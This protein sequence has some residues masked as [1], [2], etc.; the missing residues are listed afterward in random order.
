MCGEQAKGPIAVCRASIALRLCVQVYV[1]IQTV[2]PEKKLNAEKYCVARVDVEIAATRHRRCCLVSHYCYG[3][4]NRKSCVHVVRAH[5]A[6]DVPCSL[7]F[8]CPFVAFVGGWTHAVKPSKINEKK[9]GKTV[10]FINM[11]RSIWRKLAA[12]AATGHST[13]RVM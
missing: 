2:V 5:Y 7:L 12:P 8:F 13:Y 1:H 11:F 10:Y 9:F 6:C 3:H 4:I